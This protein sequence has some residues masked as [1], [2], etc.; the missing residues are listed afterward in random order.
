MGGIF[1]SYRREDSAAWAGRIW[2][3]LNGA[4]GTERVFM[5]VDSLN[6]GEDFLEVIERYI[7]A[8]D[9]MLV[10]IGPRWLDAVD[11]EGRRRLDLDGD[12]VALEI[13]QALEH[14]RRVIPVLVDNAA[15][16]TAQQLPAPLGPLARRHAIGLTHSGFRRDIGGLIDALSPF[17]TA[18]TP[19]LED[20]SD[21]GSLK[22]TEVPDPAAPEPGSAG[23]PSPVLEQDAPERAMQDPPVVGASEAPPQVPAGRHA[24]GR[25]DPPHR[26]GG[27]R[28]RLVLGGIGAVGVVLAAGLIW[29]GGGS[30]G[31]GCAAIDMAVSPE[32]LEL[33]T[34]LAQ[35]FNQSD[36]AQ[37]DDACVK[38]VPH[39]MAS[40]LGASLL[41]DG[42]D[43]AEGPKPVVWSPASS[44]WGAI[45]DQELTDQGQ[46]PI[47]G[48]G[49]PFMKTP[50]VIAMPRTMAEVIGWPETPIGWSDVF[51][52]ATDGEGWA[53]HGHPEWG[54][55]RL[56]KTNPNF[57]TSG[58]SALVAQAYAATGKVDGLTSDDLEDAAVAEF[59]TGVESAVVHYGDTTLTFL[60][61]LYRADRR[62]AGLTYASAIAVEEKSVIDYNLG[63]PDGIL[64]KDEV[65][66]PPNEPLVAIY[67]AEGT[68]MSDNPF[69]VLDAEWVSD[70]EKQGARHFEEFVQ[71]PTNQERVLA[72]GF[73]PGNPE[74]QKVSPVI[75]E[76]N[77]VDPTE[78]QPLFS[79]PEPAVLDDLLTHWK[80][81]RKPARVEL[82]I[83][84]SG[85]MDEPAGDDS[86]ATKLEL[87][88]EAALGAID[89]FGPRD[90]VGLRVF[91]TKLGEDDFPTIL[92]PEDEEEMVQ[93]VAPGVVD[94]GQ[95]RALEEALSGLKPTNGTPL[96][97]ATQQAFDDVTASYDP[98]S[99]NAVVLLSDGENDDT[100]P[101]D[102]PDQLEELLSTLE[103]EE[104]AQSHPVRVFPIVYGADADAEK[105]ERIAEA[106]DSAVYSATDPS[107]IDRV[108]AAVI[109]NF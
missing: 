65:P 22:P 95:R 55:F 104:G 57:S 5:D 16:P 3:H 63:N 10:V 8:T 109:S 35:T 18:D 60:N 40:G 4:F 19:P 46:D 51:E 13:G 42:W 93:L 49:K 72:F 103:G 44:G 83:D 99:I 23:A 75:T 96:Y 17:L 80:E 68:I 31:E 102:D 53:A 6:L 62:G 90:V 48:D 11:G 107:K 84:I 37:V 67:P 79:M 15:M 33:L 24:A 41:T 88:V 14:G 77:G 87:A 89:Q 71:E 29:A 92:G 85:S 76:E 26:P 58:L 54:P 108:L 45:V 9:V 12:F 43:E 64:D 56:G 27:R 32:K 105:L 101:I 100:D 1:I 97:A 106:S 7:A 91:S 28:R 78:P 25:G 34:D 52:L 21:E 59:A 36:Q 74:V 38:V 94:E 82:V 81:Q 61:N 70:L 39:R 73:R 69:F 66:R 50:L 86:G 2:E 98:N 47:A 30:S 20:A